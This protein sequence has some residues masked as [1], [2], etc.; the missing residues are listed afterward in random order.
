MRLCK[1]NTTRRLKCLKKQET[2][3]KVRAE[4]LMYLEIIVDLKTSLKSITE[5]LDKEKKNVLNLK[6]EKE[7]L[8]KHIADETK[9]HNVLIA[10]MKEESENISREA[11][12]K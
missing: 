2:K 4:V 1:A 10:N 3:W 7:A 8:N 5:D 9:N 6:K 11:Q 12:S